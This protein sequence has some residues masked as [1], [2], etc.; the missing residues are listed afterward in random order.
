MFRCSWRTSS[1]TPSPTPN[2][3]RGR[4]SLP[5]TL[6]MLLRGRAELCTGSAADACLQMLC[7]VQAYLKHSCRRS[8]TDVA[9]N[10]ADRRCH[11]RLRERLPS[12]LAK[13]LRLSPRGTR[14]RRRARGRSLMRSTSTRCLYQQL[15]V[16]TNALI[17]GAEASSPR[18]WRVC[19]GHEYH[20]LVRQRPLRKN[21]S[22]G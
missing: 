14:K 16:C 4:L 21:R 1:E 19:Q 9:L 11:L 3:P 17:A 20:E 18:Y 2:T 15:I 8:A 6:S 13:L 5:W 7:F 10:L 22:R 12:S